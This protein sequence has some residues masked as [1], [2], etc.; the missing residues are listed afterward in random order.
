VAIRGDHLAHVTDLR[1]YYC[2]TDVVRAVLASPHMTRVDDLLLRIDRARA[3]WPTEQLAVLVGSLVAP[4]VRRLVVDLETPA[5]AVAFARPG[6][7]P[8]LSELFV[9]SGLPL[10]GPGHDALG[11]VLSVLAGADFLGGLE[12]IEL[13]LEGPLAGDPLV[14]PAVEAALLRLLRALDP[15]RVRFLGL[16][17][18]CGHSAAVGELVAERFG[19]KVVVP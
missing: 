5:E 13:Y 6:A 2:H 16:V 9:R 12:S 18:V 14:G 1:L 7:W 3:D 15:D 17:P 4:R 10:G 19:G 11:E 8:S